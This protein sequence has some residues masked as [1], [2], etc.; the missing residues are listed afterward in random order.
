MREK[1]SPTIKLY[2]MISNT[3]F[4]LHSI[5]YN[6]RKISFNL[7]STTY[8]VWWHNFPLSSLQIFER[9]M[10]KITIFLSKL[11]AK[12]YEYLVSDDGI[13]ALF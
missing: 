5:K 9:L 2:C 7:T 1:Y 8:T 6:L 11:N 13:L 4:L 10:P 12:I 3:D